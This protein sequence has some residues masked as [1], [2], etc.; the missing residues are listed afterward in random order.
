MRAA[1]PHGGTRLYFG[2]AV[3]PVDDAR[4]G[5]RRIGT[6]FVLLLGFHRVY[7]RVLLWAARARLRRQAR[8]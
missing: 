4:T 3:V 1:A 7:S 5:R 8:G 2:S 6:V